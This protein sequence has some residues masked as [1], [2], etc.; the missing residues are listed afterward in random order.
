[1]G[2]TVVRET[3][4]QHELWYEKETGLVCIVH[5]GTMNGIDAQPL[6]DRVAEYAEEYGMPIFSLVDNR[7]A[8]GFTNEARKIMVEAAP[9]R[10]MIVA[11]Y[12]A[13]FVIQTLLNMLFRAS[14]AAKLS[15]SIVTAC[16]SESEARAWLAEQQRIRGVRVAS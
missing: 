2:K 5:I 1:M 10:E 8:T 15:K 16:N 13:S 9:M 12:G 4:G 11:L 6:C 3:F 7:R 14:R